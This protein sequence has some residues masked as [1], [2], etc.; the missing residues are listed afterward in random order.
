MTHFLAPKNQAAGYSLAGAIA[1]SAPLKHKRGTLLASYL[2]LR[3]AKK[4]NAKNGIKAATFF[5][6][7]ICRN[8]GN[9]AHFI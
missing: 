9:I 2:I 1:A 4:N 6:A 3:K 8:G 7:A 5:F